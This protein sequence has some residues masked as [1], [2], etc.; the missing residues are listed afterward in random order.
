MYKSI[1]ERKPRLCL[2][3]KAKFISIFFCAFS[4]NA[5]FISIDGNSCPSNFHLATRA[6]ASLNHSEVCNML[7]EDEVLRLDDL[8]SISGA[9]ANCNITD[10]D[11]RQLNSSLCKSDEIQC[12][13]GEQVI[14]GQKIKDYCASVTLPED[15]SAWS[16]TASLKCHEKGLSGFSHFQYL[17]LPPG[18]DCPEQVLLEEKNIFGRTVDFKFV[19]GSKTAFCEDK[20][21][22]VYNEDGN[23]IA[24]PYGSELVRGQTAEDHCAFYWEDSGLDTN[25]AQVCQSYGGFKEYQYRLL[26]DDYAPRLP[27]YRPVCNPDGNTVFVSEASKTVICQDEQLPQYNESGDLLSCPSYTVRVNGHSPGVVDHCAFLEGHFWYGLSPELDQNDQ[28]VEEDICFTVARRGSAV[29]RV[30]NRDGSMTLLC[31]KEDFAHPVATEIEI[32]ND[33]SGLSCDNNTQEYISAN[34]QYLGLVFRSHCA[35]LPDAEQ[36]IA[37]GLD[38]NG[39]DVCGEH[40]QPYSAFKFAGYIYPGGVKTPDCQCEGRGCP[41]SQDSGR[42]KGPN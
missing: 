4:A 6:E 31:S 21:Q 23:I 24:C 25:G 13:E 30:K 38:I 20:V 37:E 11:P 40:S 18:S 41:S 7:A 35:W 22:P 26:K 33:P 29:K 5:E 36:F 34:R 27:E 28:L 32:A 10:Y 14:R 2:A 16:L 17:H 3:T 42:F 39:V 8:A 12:G 19:T 15:L 1:D 9:G